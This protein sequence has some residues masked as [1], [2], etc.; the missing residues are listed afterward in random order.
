MKK[1]LFILLAFI[2]VSVQWLTLSAQT[3][4][5]VDKNGNRVTYDVS[6]LDSVTFQQDPPAI[7]VYEVVDQANGNGGQ[8]NGDPTVEVTQYTFDDVKGLAGEPGFFFAHPDTV[9]V[10]GEGETFVFQLRTSVD[11]DYTPGSDWLSFYDDIEETDSLLFTAGPN[12]MTTPRSSYVIFTGKDGVM[13]DTLWVVQSAKTDSRYIDI[14]WS[15]T[16]LDNFNEESGE[17]QLTFSGDVPM[18]GDYDVV[19]LPSNGD[20]TI[21]LIDAVQQAEGS[22]TVTLST[23]QGVMGNLFKDMRFNLSTDT[24][25]SAH[26]KSFDVNGEYIPTYTPAK[27]E[28]LVG[29]EFVEMYDSGR[30]KSRS[31]RSVDMEHEFIHKEFNA[32]GKVLW[33]GGNIG[34]LSWEKLNFNLDLKGLFSF[35]FGDIPFEKVRMGDLQNLK[36]SL[37]GGVDMEMLLNYTV[38]GGASWESDPWTL[39]KNVIPTKRFTF[40]VGTVPVYITVGADLLAEVS[41]GASGIATI[42]GGAKASTT[43]TYGVEWDAEEGLKKIS[44]SERSFEMLGPT[45]KIQACADAE[46]TA[47]PKIEIGIYKVLCP[48]IMPKAYIRAAAHGQSVDAQ[49]VAWDAG[50]ETGVDLG[51]GL[52]LDLFFWK[53]DLG[54]I[55]PIN[56]FNF[57]LVQ[58]PDEIKL[59]N[60]P[61]EE[62]LLNTM[63]EVKYHVTNKNYITGTEY[64]A[65]AMLVHFTAEGGELEDEYG[66]TDS[67]GNVSAFFTLRDQKGGKIMAEVVKGGSCDEE[68]GDGDD[69][70]DYNVIKADDWAAIAIQN[71]LTP[72]PTKQTIAEDAESA[73]ITFKL[74]QYSSKTQ[75]WK[76][77]GNKTIYFEA[78]GGSC[79]A[80]GVTTPDGIATATFTPEED[81]TEGS[82]TGTV[83]LSEPGAWSGIATGNIYAESEDPCDTGDEDLNKAN[84]QDNTY[85]VENK[86]TGE[87]QT[88]SYVPKWSEWSTDQDAIHFSLEDA[89]AEGGTLGMVYGFIPL[90]MKDVVLTLTG[91][92]FENT[93]GAKFGFG[94]YEGEFVEADFAKFSGDDAFGNIKPESK[95]MLRQPCN[96]KAASSAHSTSSTRGESEYTGDY[97][98]LFYLVFRN[99]VWNDETGQMEDGD[100]YVI[101][102]KGTMPM[103]VPHVTWMQLDAEDDWVKVG[104]S[105]VVNL[106]DYDEKAAAWDWNDVELIAQAKNGNDA[107]NGANEGYFSWDAATHTLTSLKSNENK[108]VTL[109]FA[110]KSNPEVTTS[111]SIRTGEGWKYTSISTSETEMTASA[112][113]YFAFSF[114]WTPKD[115]ESEK[116]DYYS[117]EIDPATNPDGYFQL[118]MQYASQGWPMQCNYNTPPG[119]Y[120]IRFRLKSNHDVYTTMKIIIN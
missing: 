81:F 120:N 96:Q 27:V 15:T 9:Y 57:P 56:V 92:T 102:G 88:R 101:Y 111:M 112:P 116:F 105:T 48:T 33:D 12:P 2:V 86:T 1:L 47:Y 79:N 67:E 40:Y 75:T 95:I 32:D 16:T 14:D 41:L 115:S 5:V 89:D 51:L 49:Y 37:Q 104:N 50:I 24:D 64:N 45:V 34:T 52:C 63:K 100:D 74:E 93:P 10:D 103:H 69:G 76:G 119:E 78:K 94:I 110:L 113:T 4:V 26:S 117:I 73:T 114:N 72:E 6:K 97:E 60:E 11:Y 35:D 31:A 36:I 58:L 68:E 70:D 77:I 13:S 118:S 28:V 29:D 98:L 22:K 46:A 61:E 82:V 99:Q 55:E 85:V 91:Q 17:A 80:S 108:D 23:R 90:T 71:R 83:T 65:E 25:G 54:E 87:T 106:V 30:A 39:M 20:Y 18:M 53:K 7:T 62:M 43:V 44:E 21:R 38:K 8:G 66:Y 59:L 109:R 19:L 42:S 84:L 107:W 3:F